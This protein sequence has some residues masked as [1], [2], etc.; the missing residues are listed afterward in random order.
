MPGRDPGREDLIRQRSKQADELDRARGTR[1]RSLSVTVNLVEKIVCRMALGDLTVVDVLQCTCIHVLGDDR[2]P[3]D[4][5]NLVL[6]LRPIHRR[7][8]REDG[9]C[10]NHVLQPS[11]RGRGHDL[12][13]NGHFD[14][15]TQKNGQ[16]R[17]EEFLGFPKEILNRLRKPGVIPSHQ[18]HVLADARQN[19]ATWYSK[20]PNKKLDDQG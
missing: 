10:R 6:E 16:D 4:L 3:K 8:Q 15:V 13:R 17:V 2:D 18:V 12:R 9:V 5:T 19:L 14:P 1:T 20:I 7:D 11:D